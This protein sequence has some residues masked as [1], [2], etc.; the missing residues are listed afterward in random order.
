MQ[1]SAHW[2]TI[3]DN[4]GEINDPKEIDYEPLIDEGYFHIHGQY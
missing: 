1:S 2:K 4:K 3:R